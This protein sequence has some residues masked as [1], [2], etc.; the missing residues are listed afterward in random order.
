LQNNQCS[1][2]EGRDRSDY[3]EETATSD[4]SCFIIATDDEEHKNT[5]SNNVQEH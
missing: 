2:T 4:D 5:G 3:S 1:S